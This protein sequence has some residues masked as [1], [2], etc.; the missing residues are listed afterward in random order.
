MAGIPYGRQTITDDDV[1]AVLRVLR[2]EFLTQGP[3][4]ERFEDDCMKVVGALN[5]VA[6]CNGTAALHV[7]AMALGARTG[8]K[9]I[10]P[11]ITFAASANCIRYCGGDVIFCDVDAETGCLDLSHVERILEEHRQ[12]DGIVAVDLAGYPVR[13]DRLRKLTAE[14]EIW[15]LEDA[16]HALGAAFFDD[17]G[18]RQPCAG[19]GLVDAATLS[20]HPVKH[21][22]TGEGGMA[23]TRSNDLAARMRQLRTH[24]ITRDPSKLERNDGPWY[25]EMTELGFN[26]R[27]PDVLCALG[28]S[29]ISR[30]PTNLE[31]RR[32][33]ARRYD[34]ELACIGDLKLPPS[35]GV[36]HAYHLY[37]IRSS[38]RNE[39]YGH[40][41]ENGVFAQIHYVPVHTFPYYRRL[42]GTQSL[43][44]AESYYETCLSIPMYHGLTDDQQSRV[45][46]SIAGFFKQK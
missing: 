35:R 18:V 28:S 33:I 15:I 41:R 25:Y 3:A 27:M 26:Y 6:V 17:A 38:R 13:L 9:V 8:A 1:E 16:S 30:L 37:A 12:I 14:R 31:R 42:Y 29:Q 45:I 44:N 32:E 22:A 19:S 34:Q 2:S 39:L 4:V 10:V 21:I 5:A 40:L 23:T 20:F 24:G 36:D 11:A 46:E 7:A 43:P